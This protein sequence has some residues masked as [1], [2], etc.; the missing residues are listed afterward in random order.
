MRKLIRCVAAVALAATTVLP[1]SSADAAILPKPRLQEWWFSFWDIQNKVWPIT[2]GQGVTV[3]VL[4]SGVNAKLPGLRGVVVPGTNTRRG[5]TGDGR[6]D[7]DKLGH[8][9]E[10]AELIAGQGQDDGM[11]GVAPGVKIMPIVADD[12]SP[13]VQADAIRYAVDHG[14]KVISISLAS[15]DD[16]GPTCIAYAPVLQQAVAYAAEKNVVVVAAAGNQGNTTNSPMAPANCAGVL[17]VGAIDGKKLAW[18]HSENQPYVSVAAPGLGTGSV[19]KNGRF[20]GSSGTSNA[21]ALTAGEAALVRSKFPNLS[22]REVV[23]RIINTTV[24]AGPPGHDNYTGSG[25]AVP[26]LA[27]TRDVDKAAPNP[28][29]Q[30]LDQWLATHGK[31]SGSSAQSGKPSA[32]GK[33]SGSSSGSA[34]IW[35][36]IALL[37]VVAVVVFLL[38]RRRG[39]RTPAAAGPPSLPNERRQQPPPGPGQPPQNQPWQGQGPRQGGPPPSF[40]PPDGQ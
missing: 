37:I 16:P 23:Q 17:A 25:A 36:L 24:E 20:F 38:V 29:F 5:G 21:A 19:G 22:A 39:S 14:A 34:M 1:A 12:S 18:T 6:V 3:A 8:G 27:L 2:Q 9:T 13:F 28:T 26:I 30:R 10:M 11:V 33:S 4:D 7:T 31:K 40:R 35:V 15:A 32:A